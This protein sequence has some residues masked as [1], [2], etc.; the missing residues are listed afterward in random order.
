MTAR[1]AS[2]NSLPGRGTEE[3]AVLAGIVDGRK[4]LA[5][6]SSA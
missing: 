1:P 6:M 4:L 2:I 5:T 3:D